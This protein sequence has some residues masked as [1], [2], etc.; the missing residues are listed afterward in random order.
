MDCTACGENCPFVKN[1]LCPSEKECPNYIESW[2]Q[3]NGQGQPKIIRDCAPKRMLIQQQFEVNRL[4]AIQQAVEQMRNSLDG[5][6]AI[7]TQLMNQS[8]NYI[9]EK[10]EP[11]DL[12]I[13]HQTQKQ[14][15]LK[16]CGSANNGVRKAP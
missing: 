15:K 9:L 4:F 5:L 3:E 1:K 2:W 6:T 16:C 8:K 13:P 10:V 12:Q 7:L 11:T 14:K